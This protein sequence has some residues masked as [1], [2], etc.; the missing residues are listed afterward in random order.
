MPCSLLVGP[1]EDECN[2]SAWNLKYIELGTSKDE[3]QSVF[4]DQSVTTVCV[5]VNFKA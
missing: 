5:P 3:L 2:V 4:K 1:V